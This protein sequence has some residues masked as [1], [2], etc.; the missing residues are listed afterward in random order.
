[1]TRHRHSARGKAAV[2]ILA[3][4]AALGPAGVRPVLS[5]DT[6]LLRFSTAKPYVFF[7]LDTS[8]SMTLT[9]DGKWVHANG[10]DPRSKLY[11]AKRVLYEVFQE[12][13][14]IHFGF[15]AMNQDH[16][17][18]TAKHWLYYYAGALPGGWPINYPRPDPDGPVQI[19]AN[20]TAVS[21]V[22]GDL[23]T[24]GPH[25]DAAGV[26]GSCLLPLS[27]STQGEKIN[28]YSKLGASGDG[29]TVVWISGPGN[30]TYRLTVTRPG[31]K[32]DTS[33]NPKLGRDKMNVKFDLDEI[34]SCV[35]PLIQKSHTTNFDLE[36][37]TDFLMFDENVGSANAPNGSHNG[38][39]DKVAG[40]WDFKDIADAATCGSGHPF[41]GK[42]WE[43]NYDGAAISPPPGVAG[44]IKSTEDPHCDVAGNPATC[45]NL[46]AATQF[47]PLGRPL[48]RGDLIPLDWRVE[49]KQDFLDRLAFQN[50]PD[51]SRD[52]GIASY[53]EDSPDATTGV[54]PLANSGPSPL[55][56]TGPSPLGKMV[57]DFRCWYRGEGNKCND[58]AYLPGWESIAQSRD[59]EWGCRRPYLIV[60][61]DGGDS[62][63]GENPCADTA[64]LNS[65]SGVRT[66]VV[67]Y[68][69]NCAAAG[70]P[71]KCMAQNGKGEL[72][73]PQTA[74]DLKTELLAIL[75][76][77]REET[78][79]FASAAVPSVQAIVEDKIFLT[80]FTPLQGKSVWDG[81]VHSFLKPLPLRTSDG[82]PDVTHPNHLW[83]GAEVMRTTQVN[84]ADPLGSAANQR[85][86]YYSR[87][88]AGLLTGN[89]RL[90]DKTTQGVEAD[91]VRRDLWRA[92]EI[93]FIAGDPITE[94][95]AELRANLV[96][97]KTLAVKS[98]TL[99]SIDPVT[100]QPTTRTIEY[101]LGDIFHSNPLVLGSPPN[102]LYFSTDLNGYRDFF[103]KHEFRRKML[104]VGSNDGMLH[105][106]D[107]G[108]FVAATRK[109]S[110]GTGKELFAYIPREEMATVRRLAEG[111][112]HQ[113]G[114]DGTVTVA[115]A[116][117]DPTH[118]GT[119]VA[120]NRG[121]RTVA[122]GG[123][124]EGG[125]AY[126][127]LDITQPDV[128]ATVAGIDDVPQPSNGYVPSC[129]GGDSGIVN[130]VACG[131]LPFPAPLWEFND[132]VQGVK[133]DEDANG[134]ADLGFTWS[135][136]NVG[137]I[138]LDEGAGAVEKYVMVAGGGFDP[139][140]KTSPLRGTWLYMID[141]ETGKAIYKRRLI[142]AVP[143]EPAAVDTDQ[144]GFFDRIYV[145]TTGG[146]MYR[147]DLIADSSGNFPSLANTT[148]RG[149]DGADY[150]VERVPDSV[151]APRIIFNANTDA[152][153]AL[154]AG[155]VRPIYYR[156][157]I[158]F[159]AKL[160]RYALSFGTGDREDLW[161]NDGIT[162]RFYVFV[163]DT[164]LLP[165]G[166][167]LDEGDFQRILV[168][169][170]TTD[171]QYLF[172]G[173]DGRRGWYLALDANERLITDP[174][175]LS[176]VSFFS[177][178]KPDV[179]VLGGKDPLCSKTGLSRIFV[180]STV[181]ANP[182]LTDANSLPVRNIE[183][184]DFV[185]NPFTE[186]GLTKNPSGGGGGA[187][188]E[189]CDTPTL[190]R[191]KQGLMS[192]F[193]VNCKFSNQTVDIKTISSDTRLLCIAPIPVCTIKKN[194]KEQ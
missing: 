117:I 135:I 118:S 53:F 170:G 20:G 193:P 1:M 134:Q 99:T 15:A 111:T 84:A 29:P 158:I 22:E 105:A 169:D 107:A 14:D 101:L 189:I 34:A 78:R 3:I 38:G 24:F 28:R 163:D 187:P 48:D 63:T 153:T 130:P 137:R 49:N 11:Q 136:P 183:V 119:P 59:S 131:P 127:A 152:G 176:G 157:S 192:L 65:K 182:F 51:G 147:V 110:N 66:W 26:A 25:F 12:V 74:T 177:T 97:Q 8:A 77:I 70:N 21:D 96:I 88:G 19:Q 100:G 165:S 80:N 31:T 142:G 139:D 179:Q 115:D 155:Q 30:K 83:D 112:V 60:I 9:P 93:P 45:Y 120:A 17:A 167:V 126:Y 140:N 123:L 95:A 13:D 42:G 124:R 186:A 2:P 61:S 10:D 72:L 133:L 5:D 37:W 106:F 58:S 92:F 190:Q 104:L 68:G 46:K 164:E 185:T 114:V 50:K 75:G 172:D 166:T 36:L 98:H 23:L 191:V 62:C 159:V 54:L 90:L 52:F 7:L 175:A 27:L 91:E 109:F 32:P 132:T 76:Q 81:H 102:T 150:T 87:D 39:V 113:W 151:W 69:A 146:L 94:A 40:F 129:L 47:D 57:I 160:G 82:K 122:F 188:A 171:A 44:S 174:F 168:G 184:K 144:D 43:G 108:T 79:A 64:D 55:F 145:G 149:L 162:G 86:V 125:A 180:V 85:R 33:P 154:A 156:P 161:N 181:N 16:S 6:D 4:L 116:F 67:A 18:A 143:S 73:C 41:S 194:W 128:L 141:V 178:Y 173:G 121:W 103:R 71:L 89:R 35:G 56:G 138:K 148:V